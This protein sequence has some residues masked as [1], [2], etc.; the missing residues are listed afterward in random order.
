MAVTALGYI[1]QLYDKHENKKWMYLF[2]AQVLLLLINGA[3][4]IKFSAL[5]PEHAKEIESLTMLE[6][7]DI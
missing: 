7:F 4:E 3:K 6:K 2:F 5:I 1:Q